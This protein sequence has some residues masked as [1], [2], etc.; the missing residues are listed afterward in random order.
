[1]NTFLENEITFNNS[2]ILSPTLLYNLNP[3]K[4]F[5]IREPLMEFF[6]S[7]SANK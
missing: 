4:R 1:M 2:G 5:I 6:K 7:G 3:I